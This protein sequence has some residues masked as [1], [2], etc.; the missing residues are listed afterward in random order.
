MF[1]FWFV[2][3]FFFSF[4][5]LFFLALLCFPDEAIGRSDRTMTDREQLPA[6]AI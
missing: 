6:S 2:A 4:F 5:F 1:N 3:F